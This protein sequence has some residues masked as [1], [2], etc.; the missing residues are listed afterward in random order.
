[1]LKFRLRWEPDGFT[2]YFDG[3]IYF[4]PRIGFSSTET[5]LVFF[6]NDDDDFKMKTYDT[7]L[8]NNQLFY[9]QRHNRNAFHIFDLKQLS[10]QSVERSIDIF[11]ELAKKITGLCHCLFAQLA[12]RIMTVGVK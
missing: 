1:M 11:P 7:K 8:Y 9:F 12:R 3:D 10:T 2:E 5:R 6:K 4:Q